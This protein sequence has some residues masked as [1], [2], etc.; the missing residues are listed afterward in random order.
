MITPAVYCQSEMLHEL[1]PSGETG[2]ESRLRPCPT[3]SG[4]A[5]K[6]LS[7]RMNRS[8]RWNTKAEALERLTRNGTNLKLQAGRSVELASVET[9]FR[10]VDGLGVELIQFCG[11]AR[12]ARDIVTPLNRLTRVEERESLSGRSASGPRCEQD[13]LR[14]ALNLVSSDSPSERQS[15]LE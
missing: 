15:M 2:C 9:E 3:Y 8:R 13:R 5:W 12:F 6:A 14:I 10:R 1:W 11:S 7:V 4:A